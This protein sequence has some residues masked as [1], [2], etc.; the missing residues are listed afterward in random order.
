MPRVS[1]LYASPGDG[2]GQREAQRAQGLL[3]ARD[4]QQSPGPLLSRGLLAAE[5]CTALM[6]HECW[7]VCFQ[8][9]QRLA[10]RWR[11][12]WELLS[13]AHLDSEQHDEW[14]RFVFISA[15]QGSLELVVERE[16]VWWQ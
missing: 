2:L 12:H 10:G 14:D 8:D 9:K 1:G 15:V 4:H 16:Q 5:V 7:V 11:L 3:L 6:P 13:S